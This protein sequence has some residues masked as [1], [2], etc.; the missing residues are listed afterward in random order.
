[1]TAV[2]A[3][4]SLRRDGSGDGCHDGEAACYNSHF[5]LDHY[6]SFAA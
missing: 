5:K 6:Q 2:A 3:P 1:M 4:K